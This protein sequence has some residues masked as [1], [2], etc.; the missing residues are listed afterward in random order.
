V[1]S[2]SYN[3][4]HLRSNTAAVQHMVSVYMRLPSDAWPILLAFESG[5]SPVAY[6]I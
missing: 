4:R 2:N 6:H 3:Q 1:F 5:R